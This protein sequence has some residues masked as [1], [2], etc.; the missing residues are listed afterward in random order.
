MAETKRKPLSKK[1][2]F[3]VFKRD[4]FTC[5]YCGRKSPDVILHVD[6][7]DP[8][9]KGGTNDILNLV[10]SCEECNQGK[11]D[12]PLS[13]NSVVEK[14]RKQV[15]AIQERREQMEMFFKWKKSL[16][17]LD[18][19]E[20]DLLVNYI[21]N[22]ISPF[23]LSEQ[24]KANLG[25][26][27]REFSVQDI[28]E[29]VPKG[30]KYLKTN[31]EGEFNE[32]SVVTFLK[33]LGGIIANSRKTPID[34]KLS[35]I[36]AI[37]RNSFAYWD[38]SRG[39]I[40]LNDYVKAR[41]RQGYS[42]GQILVDLD[43]EVIPRTKSARNWSEWTTIIE[44]LSEDALPDSNV[45][46][47]ELTNDDNEEDVFI[48]GAAI[49]EEE[50]I[51]T[52]S[53]VAMNTVMLYE[54]LKYIGAPFGDVNDDELMAA[55]MEAIDKY[56]SDQLLALQGELLCD[57][58]KTAINIGIEDLTADP[59][60]SMGIRHLLSSTDIINGVTFYIDEMILWDQLPKW[61]DCLYF[62]EIG[63]E[64]AEGASLF[65]ENYKSNLENEFK[66]YRDKKNHAVSSEK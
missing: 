66:E 33:K 10:T 51:E 65:I 64:D 48:D 50:I 40:L 19:Q 9:A 6:H 7:L 17:K 52:A 8:V 62:P 34:A 11:S 32:E 12:I 49:G 43:S 28:M 60:I 37:G 1:I 25:N 56:L 29:A 53:F 23:S 44:E 5:Q 61:F 39:Y 47:H 41:K 58:E 21:N 45:N 15:E 35:H 22:L 46:Q 24:G 20:I 13:D 54:F 2:R 38:D 59:T 31:N 18:E 16:E 42:E 3:E 27:A 57:D 26:L 14:Q 4:S 63:I 55:L 36:R 30:K